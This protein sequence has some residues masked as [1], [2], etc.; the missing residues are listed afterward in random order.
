MKIFGF[1]AVFLLGMIIGV[2]FLT[3]FPEDKLEMPL[4]R[5]AKEDTIQAPNDR[6]KADSIQVFNDHAVI[7]FKDLKGRKISWS[8]YADTE[9]MVPTLD[10]GCNGLEFTPA[11]PKD[12]HEGDMIAFKKNER[13]IIHRVS[14]IGQDSEGWFAI[15]KGDNNQYTDGKIRWSEVE[16]VTFGVIC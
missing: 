15:T 14:K 10:S 2:L 13:L 12:V 16:Y 1:M 9:S 4:T 5:E 7:D 11:S 3:Y 8:S 6:I